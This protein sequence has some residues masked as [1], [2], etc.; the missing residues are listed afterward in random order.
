VKKVIAIGSDHRGYNYKE[1]IKNHLLSNNYIVKDFGTDSTESVDYPDYAK[2]VADS[3]ISGDS[4]MGVLICGTGIG[5]SIAA[6]KIKGIRAANVTSEKM[7]EMSREHNNANVICFGGDI[8][9]I[10]TVIKCL[11]IFLQ[12]EFGG[13]RHIQRVAKIKALEI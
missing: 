4:E 12:R 3:V 7:V 8:M 13:G 11:E 2:K 5:V 1:Q 6:N 9:D 10:G